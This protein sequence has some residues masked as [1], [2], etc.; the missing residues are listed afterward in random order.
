MQLHNGCYYR[1]NDGEVVRVQTEK[2]GKELAAYNA[3]G[4]MV[5]RLEKDGHVNGW[6][7]CGAADYAKA[8]KAI[9]K[10]RPKHVKKKRNRSKK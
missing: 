8:R 10:P 7:P 4:D 2:M 1:T 3:A 6:E 5:L 9:Q